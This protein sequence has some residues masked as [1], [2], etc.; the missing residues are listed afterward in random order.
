MC[1]AT[2]TWEASRTG[3]LLASLTAVAPLDPLGG[4]QTALGGTDTIHNLYEWVANG[5]LKKALG[6][7]LDVWD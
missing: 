5:A 7:S 2:Q 4:K 6:L 3:S 1:M